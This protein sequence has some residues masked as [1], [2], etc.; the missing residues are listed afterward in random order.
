MKTYLA[1]DSEVTRSWFVV[2]AK[3][4]VLGRLATQI[5]TVLR[6]KHKTSFTPHVDCGDGVIVINAKELKVTGKKMEQKLYKTYSGY[7]SGL[8]EKTL[9]TML[10]SKPTKVI[11]LAVKNMLP[12]NKIGA[13]MI[14]RLK[15]YADGKHDQQAQKPKELKI[16]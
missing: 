9:E 8:K 16:G 5:A 4:K 2:D 3:D 15:V 7:P 1:K 13:K 10:A 6:G 11:M 14:K 12:K